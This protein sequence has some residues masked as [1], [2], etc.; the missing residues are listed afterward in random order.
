MASLPVD[1]D[2]T[3]LVSIGSMLFRLNPVIICID[4]FYI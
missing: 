3:I 4:I 1:P 2:A